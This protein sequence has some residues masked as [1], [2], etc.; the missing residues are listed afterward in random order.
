[1][2]RL[3]QEW[4]WL[5]LSHIPISQHN[6]AC[7]GSP[8]YATSKKVYRVEKRKAPLEVELQ[9]VLSCVM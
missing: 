8:Q 9:L 6:H 2:N 3:P 4:F 7:F 1:M 5:G